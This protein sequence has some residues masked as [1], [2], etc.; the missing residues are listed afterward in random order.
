MEPTSAARTAAGATARLTDITRGD[1]LCSRTTHQDVPTAWIEWTEFGNQTYGHVYKE[2]GDL[3]AL[4][5]IWKDN[6][7]A[8]AP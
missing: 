7:F 4:W 8:E 5:E 1:L 3:A 6:P 2:N